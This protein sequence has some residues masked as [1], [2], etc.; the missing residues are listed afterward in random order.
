MAGLRATPVS[1]LTVIRGRSLPA[2]LGGRTY[3]DISLQG[4]PYIALIIGCFI[5]FG[6]GFWADAKY[7]RVREANGGVP[8]PEYRLWGAMHFAISLPVGV[9]RTYHAQDVS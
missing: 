6:T 8:I 7:D 4:L 3:A 2:I 1:L 5:G 9:R